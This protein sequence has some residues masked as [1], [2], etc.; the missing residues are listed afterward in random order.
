MAKN[1]EMRMKIFWK[2]REEGR[3]TGG[4][5]LVKSGENGSKGDTGRKVGW[6]RKHACVYVLGNT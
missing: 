2:R 3:K 6:G 1:N 4:C 5:N